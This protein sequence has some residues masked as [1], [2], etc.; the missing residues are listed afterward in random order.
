MTSQHSIF[1]IIFRYIFLRHSLYT[2]L[3]IYGPSC[4]GAEHNHCKPMLGKHQKYQSVKTSL[5]TVGPWRL[6]RTRARQEPRFS[7][8]IGP[9]TNV[10]AMLL[11]RM[12]Y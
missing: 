2:P 1:C 12:T 7:F 9:S 11:L 8:D 5:A 6:Q 10:D 4:F 3:M